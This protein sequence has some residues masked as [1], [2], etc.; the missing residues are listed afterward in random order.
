M[1]ASSKLRRRDRC[2]PHTPLLVQGT[3]DGHYVA[4]CLACGLGGPERA[5]ASKARLAFDEA[6][7]RLE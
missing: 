2:P 6:S 4:R 7:K 5:N 3:G 1:Q